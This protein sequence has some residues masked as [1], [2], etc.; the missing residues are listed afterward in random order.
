MRGR[1]I[2]LLIAVVLGG[3]APAERNQAAVDTGFTQKLLDRLDQYSEA[4]TAIDTAVRQPPPGA[5]PTPEELAQVFYRSYELHARADTLDGFLHDGTVSGR[6]GM[7][8]T[9]LL[10]QAKAL[11][12]QSELTDADAASFTALAKA[13]PQ[14]PSLP[15]RFYA[16]VQ[17]RG[18]EAGAGEELQ[19]LSDD[20]A[21]YRR[22]FKDAVAADAAE[23]DEANKILS[24]LRAEPRQEPALPMAPPP[25]L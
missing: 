9:W 13:H 22:D 2:L 7:M 18:T 17:Q 24:L 16:L 14:D 23:N 12:A 8:A 21:A 25:P 15:Q 5:A 1:T 11:T 10:D 19:A 6:P 3:C 20:V 4:A